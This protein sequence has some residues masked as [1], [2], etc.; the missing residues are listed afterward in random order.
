MLDLS[1]GSLS[2]K[3]SGFVATLIP[4]INNSNFADTARGLTDALRRAGLQLLL[5]YTGYS[6]EKEEEPIGSM[7][8]RRPEPL[9]CRTPR[10]SRRSSHCPP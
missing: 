7:L 4:S 10:S 3:R 1:A 2:S 9:H 5:A 8:R 6:V